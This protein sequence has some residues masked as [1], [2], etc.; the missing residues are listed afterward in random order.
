MRMVSIKYKRPYLNAV[1]LRIHSSWIAVAPTQ[2]GQPLLSSKRRP[3]LQTYKWPWNEEKFGH[4]LLN[5]EQLCAMLSLYK[6]SE[7]RTNIYKFLGWARRFMEPEGLFNLS[8]CRPLPIIHS[9]MNPCYIFRNI[10]PKNLF[11]CLRFIYAE[12]LEVV[13]F[14]QVFRQ[15][16]CMHFS[17]FP[18][19][20]HSQP[21]S[22]SSI[23]PG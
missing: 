17:S 5:Q 7:L 22:F 3:G 6:I 21:I 15:K 2:K 12:V 11:K 23:S 1:W 20:L 19:L 14:L 18:F 9:H 16:F 10:F 13:S 4:G 8:K